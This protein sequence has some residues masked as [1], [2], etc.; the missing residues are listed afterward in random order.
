MPLLGAHV[1]AALGLERA[2]ARAEALGCESAQIFVAS[3]QRWQVPALPETARQGFRTAHARFGGPVLAHAAYL[4]NLASA[5]AETRRRSSRALAAELRRCDELG[6]A[7]LVLHP[8]AHLGQGV[9]A[10]LERVA[11]ELDALFAANPQLA[12]PLLLENTAGQGTVLGSD[13][14]ELGRLLERVD[15]PGR[16]GVCIDSCHAFAAG[17]PLER[18]AGYQALLEAVEA[19]P[20]LARVAAWHLNDSSH[21]LG[22]RKDRHANLGDGFIGLEFFGRVVNDPRFAETPMVLETPLGEDEQG[23]ARDLG[24]LFAL[25]GQKG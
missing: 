6:L 14:A 13:F 10:G 4:L 23:H 5:D 7:G 20:G 24:R 8:G 17:W 11:R 1:S 2:F 15:A 22:S 16:L 12:T 3:P 9:E 18:K 21:P 25:R 19:G